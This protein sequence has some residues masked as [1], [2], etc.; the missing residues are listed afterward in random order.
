MENNNMICPLSMS[1]EYD[2]PL[3]PCQY[4]CC[5]WW[6]EDAQKCAILVLAETQRKVVKK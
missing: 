3:T 1:G 6:V 2:Y 4:K 5:A